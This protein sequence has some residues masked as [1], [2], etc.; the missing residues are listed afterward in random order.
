MVTRN[1]FVSCP[2]CE[3]AHRPVALRAGERAL[4]VQCGKTLA[5]GTL[6][7]PHAPL[8]FATTAFFFAVPAAILPFVTLSKFGNSRV[9][10]LFDAAGGLWAAGMRPLAVV[11]FFCGAIAPLLLLMLLLASRRIKERG[12]EES[13]WAKAVHV[14]QHWAMPEVQVL[15]VLVAFLKLGSLVSVE[16]GPGLWCYGAMSLAMLAAWRSF[17]LG[18]P[19]FG[20]AETRTE[21]KQ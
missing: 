17:D 7:G 18:P 16:V 5:A 14:L 8:A 20:S 10:R 6:W 9:S 1:D 3:K 21:D 13:R 4:C 15:A 11:V 2:W 12:F 19:D